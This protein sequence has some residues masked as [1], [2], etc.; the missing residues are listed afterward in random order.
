[1]NEYP[2][3]DDQQEFT[4][5]EK[6]TFLGSAMCIATGSKTDGGNKVTANIPLGDINPVPSTD[7]VNNGY[8]L[9]K[10]ANGI[11]WNELDRTNIV[12]AGAGIEVYGTAGYPERVSVINPVPTPAA[13][14]ADVGKVLTV[15]QSS[16]PSNPDEIVWAAP[17][18]GLPTYDSTY[19]GRVLTVNQA[20]NG[21]E[22]TTPQGG[23]GGG[24]TIIRFSSNTNT[25]TL[26]GTTLTPT[27]AIALFKSNPNIIV[28]RYR[29][30]DNEDI[31]EGNYYPG[32]YA[33][34]EYEHYE[35]LSFFSR[36]NGTGGAYPTTE[37]IVANT[38]T[39]Q[40]SMNSYT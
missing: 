28:R 29:T 12:R 13:A 25:A 5:E 6:A 33:E 8:L 9:T 35:V 31:E 11:Q 26:N 4:S 20:G 30:W 7:N 17:Q 22:W 18:G 21:V 2:S 32:D 34:N 24:A 15:Q 39:G 19:A 3:V 1:M 14:H 37:L 27:D 10:T 23:G 16:T 38:G 36:F 40:W